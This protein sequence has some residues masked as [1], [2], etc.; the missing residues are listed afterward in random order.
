MYPA[1]R[2]PSHTLTSSTGVL[3][4]TALI[5]MMMMT[6]CPGSH[7][8]PGDVGFSDDTADAHTPSD[9]DPTEEPDTPGD[10]EDTGQDTGDDTGEDPFVPPHPDDLDGPDVDFLERFDQ[11]TIDPDVW[12]KG[13]WQE[14]DGQMSEERVF[15]DGDVLVLA[16]EYDEDFFEET[17]LFKSSSI[18]TIRE[19][20]LYGRWEARLQMPQEDGLNAAMYTIDWRDNGQMTRQEVDIEFVTRNI[21]DSHSEVHIAVHGAEFDSWWTQVTLPFNPADDFHV[22]GFDIT[23]DSITWFVD[24]IDLFTYYYDDRPGRID[25]PYR[26]KFNFWSQKPGFHSSGNWIQG[27]PTAN[28]EFHYRIDWVRFLPHD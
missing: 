4:I 21:G 17:E 3:L 22:W 13:T 5:A 26:L 28:T 25:A 2:H 24:N 1:P 10:P 16:F 14:H 18:E 19:D 20:F 27:P 6:G 15:L 12:R 8:D 7:D 9:S 23:E 11:G